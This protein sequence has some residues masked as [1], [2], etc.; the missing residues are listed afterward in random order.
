VNKIAFKSKIE[1][2]GLKIVKLLVSSGFKAFWVGGTVRDLLLRREIDNLDISTSAT[3]EQIEKI[4]RN[5]YIPYRAVGKEYGTILAITN[6]GPVEITTFRKEGVYRDRRR[7]SKVSFIEDYIKDSERRDFTINALYFDPIKKTLFDPQKGQSDLDK[8]IIRFVGDPKKR[9][10]EDALRMLRA[11][12]FSCQ[13]N[14]KIE[15]NSFAAI[16]TRAKY[17][18][19]ISSDRI[20]DEINKILLHDNREI[21]I[22]LMDEIGL[23]KFI[24]P[25]VVELKKVWHKS[26]RYH[27]E[28]NVFE[29]TLLTLKNSKPHDLIQAYA[30]LYHDT[31]KPSTIVPKL[32]P[33]GLVNSFPGHEHVSTDIFKKFAKNIKLGRKETNIIMW[34]TR[35]H[36]KRV[37]FVKDM[38]EDK[39]IDLAMHKYFPELI[40]LWR[41]DALSNYIKVDDKIITGI[42]TAYQEGLKL[43]K[44]IHSKKKIIDKIAQ[45]DFIMQVLNSKPG[46]HIGTIKKLLQKKIIYGEIK[47]VSDAKSFLK[48]YKK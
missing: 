11:V 32:K 7:P 10:D 21:G 47:N 44:K 19:S 48:K 38:S 4:L 29:H 20:R 36:M 39:K 40:E 45:G 37:A 25:E 12:R 41:A 3:P 26:K 6:S 31:G 27:L 34:I 2:E 18:Q 1:I 14:F 30:A 5:D 42:P 13:L 15:K 28:G 8:N 33:E 16:K 46:L 17:I 23:L 24:M 9:I 22:R 43:L 35:M